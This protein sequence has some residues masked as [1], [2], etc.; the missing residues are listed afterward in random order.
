MSENSQRRSNKTYGWIRRKVS[1]ARKGTEPW[2][3]GTT[4]AY[5]EEYIE[6]IRQANIGK[7]YSKDTLAKIS[8]SLTGKK[9][10]AIHNKRISEAKAGVKRAPFSKEWK[11]KIGAANRGPQKKITCPHCD[12][13]GGK[14]LMKRYHFDNCKVAV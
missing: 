13:M 10:S 9:N 14:S 2:N 8:A 12:K 6:K 5:S 11:E 4:G 1:E 7:I 3:K